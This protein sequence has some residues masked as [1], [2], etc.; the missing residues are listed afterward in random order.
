M[1]LTENDRWNR[2]FGDPTLTRDK[3]KL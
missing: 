2:T 1:F 3:T